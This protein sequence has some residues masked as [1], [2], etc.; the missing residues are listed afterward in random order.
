MH[1]R[2]SIKLGA[3]VAAIGA[4]VLVGAIAAR[5]AQ[6]T[7]TTTQTLAPNAVT[8]GLNALYST[9]YQNTSG[10]TL[11]HASIFVTLPAGSVFQFAAPDL[12]TAAAAAQDGTIPVTCPRGRC[13]PDT[14]SHSR[15][16]FRRRPSTRDS[17]RSP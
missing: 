3:V 9:S 5:G 11:T 4:A 6:P 12:C 14:S 1:Y 7:V 15:S 17:S 2:R 16:S 10:T 13:R 8:S